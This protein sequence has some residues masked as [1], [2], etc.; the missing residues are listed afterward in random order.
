MNKNW[1]TPQE[2]FWAGDF[3]TEYV[4]RNAGFDVRS[5][6]SFFAR[7]FDKKPA[8]ESILELGSNIG[9]NLR[10]LRTLFPKAHIA[11]VEINDKAAEQL[12][13]SRVADEVF[14]SSILEFKPVRRYDFVF[15]KGVLIHLNPDALPRVYETMVNASERYVLTAEYYSPKPQ[16]ID[17]R[18]HKGVLFKRDFAGELMAQFP[19]MGLVDYGFVYRKDPNFPQDDLTWFLMEKR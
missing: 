10:A 4:D 15:T 18:E 17:Y 19:K 11:A 8:P 5:N 3:G 13:A 14:H 16:E 12:K 7:I 2:S 1:S 6:I 9:L